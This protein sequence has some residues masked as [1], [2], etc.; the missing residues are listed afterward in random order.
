M[1]TSQSGNMAHGD[2]VAG[3]QSKTITYVQSSYSPLA[4]LYEKLRAAN[5]G[6]PCAALIS[7]QLQHYCSVDSSGDV[8]GLADKLN[9]AERGDL[10]RMASTMKEVA[11]KIIMKW[12]TS[13]VAQ[14]IITFVL[15]HLYSQFALYAT[16]AIQEGRPRS[17]VDA[18]ISERVIKP[19]AEIL[20]ENDLMLTTMDLLGLLFFLGGNCH[21]RWDKC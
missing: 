4:R 7:D 11:S 10:V 17:E 21:V 5:E 13:G 3:N 8:R 19:T 2:I 14:D 16:P 1:F 9:A 12:Q 20:G 18:I 6:L 15:S